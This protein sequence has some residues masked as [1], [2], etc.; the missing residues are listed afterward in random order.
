MPTEFMHKIAGVLNSRTEV[1]MQILIFLLFHL[2]DMER[3]RENTCKIVRCKL[4]DLQVKKSKFEQTNHDLQVR[5][6]TK[7]LNKRILKLII[8][9]SA[10]FIIN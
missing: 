1:P 4:T 5:K 7:R 8:A 6:I 9:I 3:E 2:Q 10:S